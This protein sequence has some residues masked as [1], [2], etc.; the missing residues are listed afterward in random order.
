MTELYVGKSCART[1]L[2]KVT[3]RA[4]YINDIRVPRMLYGK[5]LY[6]SRPH[7]RIKS[8]DISKAEKLHGVRAVLTGFN[9]PDV[10]VGFLGDQAPLKK[11]K[12]RQFRDEIAAVAATDE[13]I[14]EEALGLITVEYEDLPA[15]FDPIQAMQKD[16][17]LI[18]E[19]DAR[20]KPRRNNI[21]PLPWKLSAGDVEKARTE[22]A[23]V[24]KDTF[25]TQWVHQTCMGTSGGIAEFDANSN[26]I[27]RSVT[28]VPFGGKDRLDMFLKNIGIA[29]AT[30]VLTPFV[31]GSFGSKLDT[32]IYEFILVLLA[33]ATKCPV[34]IMFSRHEE[35]TA[36][37]PRQPVIATVEQGCDSDGRLTFRKVDMILDNGAYTSWGATTPS[38]MMIPISSLYRVPNVDFQATCVY[39]NNIYAQAMRGYGN[40]QATYVVEQSMDQ[41]AEAAG[42]DPM[43][44]R[45]INANLPYENTPM[46]L[47]VTTC[48]MKECLDEVKTKLNWTATH[49][50]RTG[51]GVGVASFL[52]VGG[53]ARVYLSDAQGIIL[54]VDDDGK[55]QVITGG[56]DQGQGS[57]TIIRQMVAEATGF[58][59][60]DV[61]IFLGD[62]EVCPWDVGTHASRHA[63]MVGHAILLAAGE[64]KSKVLALASKWMANLM[65]Q[66]FQKKARRDPNFKLPELDYGVLS[67]PENLDIQN[68]TVFLKSEPD[69]SVFRIPAARIL[70]K[71]HLVGTGKGEM[72]TAEAF[73]DP[74][75][76]MLDRDGKGNLSCCY[77]FGAHGVEVEVDR[78]TGQVTILNYVAAHDVGRA[79]NPMLVKGQ[80]YGATIMGAGYALTE[81]IQ[82]NHGRV[83]NPNLL[84]YKILTAKDEIPIDAVIIEPIEPTG[85]F[86]AKGI[87]E[88]ACVP[89][90]PA[91][92]NAI[93][94]AIGVRIKDLPVTPEKIL[95][96]LK[97]QADDHRPR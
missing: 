46:G 92:A 91:I 15:V 14:A 27:F 39:T 8:I 52:H 25:T 37:P 79:I 35:F 1:D 81:E 71:A 96:A 13:D 97:S 78:E 53:G 57:E 47:K 2:D 62:T 22:S 88:P 26:L 85:P 16:A 95:A 64:V 55:V 24:V 43:D 68:G 36:S 87:G 38:V 21:L 40:P 77:T 42:I 86:G 72:V 9:T 23:F 80:I 82:V 41:L 4:A 7:A 32:D 3:G 59:P 19:L 61:T 50:K 90:A 73:Y 70:R 20:G 48:P 10:R 12:V 75:N 33:W 6:S 69:N 49:G 94:D 31:G 54:K 29:G 74:P 76:E 84:D 65:Q 83:M 44:F 66:D 5:I 89:S 63:F 58:K 28:N 30:R 93:Y 17:P 18:H 56:T 11:D 45:S 60:E 67:D 34:K 51:R